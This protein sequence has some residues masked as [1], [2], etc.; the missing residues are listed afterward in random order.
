MRNHRRHALHASAL[1][2]FLWPWASASARQRVLQERAHHLRSGADP[3]WRDSAGHAHTRHLALEF[4]VAAANAT[5]QTLVLRQEDVKQPWRLLVNGRAVGLLHQDENPLVAYWAIPPG[6]L[7]AGTNTLRVEPVDKT[8]DDIWV[9]GIEL[10]DQPLAAALLQASVEVEVVDAAS[11]EPLPARVTIADLAGRLQTVGAS[12]GGMLAVRPGFVY[13]GNG[14][15]AFG[16]PAGSY[17]LF[18]TRGFEYG[19]DSARLLLRPGDRVRRRLAVRREVPTPGWVAS[20]THVHTRT[21]SGHGDATAAERVLTLAGEG[22][23]LPIITDHNV[24]VDLDSLATAMGV[25]AH[26]TPVVGNEVTTRVGHFNIFPVAPGAPP[27][28]ARAESWPAVFQGIEAAGAR[29][30]ILNHAR[31]IHAGFRPFGAERHIAVA[32]VDRD[33]W[34][35]RANAM[36][37][38]NSGAQQTDVWRLVTDW[39]GMLNGGHHL[40]PVGSSDSHDVSRYVVG[41]ARTYIRTGDDAPGRIDVAEAVERFRAGAV[42]VSFGLL[43]ELT[44]RISCPLA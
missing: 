16:L 30:V 35:L 37:L 1:A 11:G 22:I 42:M 3:E 13:T 39:F 27:P 25:R 7:A 33:G 9:G 34:A 12:S 41:Q 15:A 36:E 5:E 17:R 31:D 4:T 43:T 40:T 2:L 26:F 29:A 8:A 32:G 18:A 38:V 23:E 10:L 21:F 6:A 44:V 28:D 19:V 20:D 14:R 24:Q